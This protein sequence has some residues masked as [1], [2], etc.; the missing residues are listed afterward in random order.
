MGVEGR[1]SPFRVSYLGMLVS[2]HVAFRLSSVS[3]GSCCLVRMFWGDMFFLWGVASLFK[4]DRGIHMVFLVFSMHMG[5]FGIKL[6]PGFPAVGQ[7]PVQGGIAEPWP[8]AAS[9][10]LNKHISVFLSMFKLMITL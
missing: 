1:K 4:S 6:P 10:Y 2:G 3:G 5:Y 7:K 9:S 8:S